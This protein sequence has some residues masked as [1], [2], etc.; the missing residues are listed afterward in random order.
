MIR[1]AQ[2]SKTYKG[3]IALDGLSLDIGRGEIFGLLGHNGAGKSTAFGLI[4]G[5]IFPDAG[6]AF[7]RDISV[8]KNRLAA[9]RGVG[10]IFETPA[11]YD[12][13]SGWRNLQIFTSYSGAVGSEEIQE[14]V[15]LVGLESRIGEPVCVYSHGMRQR[16]ALAQALLPAPDV[17]LLD[18]PTEGLDPEGIHEIRKLIQK[19]NHDRGLTVLLSSHLLSEVEHLCDRVAILNA[20]KL[21]FNGNWSALAIGSPQFRLEVDDWPVAAKIAEALGAIIIQ[22]NLVALDTDVAEL[23]TRCVQAGLRVRAVEPVKRSLEQI[24]LEKVTGP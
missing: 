18:E 13:L 5:Q 10:A 17:V 19:L 9:L 2:L 11:F 24:Y 8:Q 4:L 1:L 20:G 12:Y 6:E 16:L 14:V 3:R 7:I 15:R 23:V 21:V 22:P